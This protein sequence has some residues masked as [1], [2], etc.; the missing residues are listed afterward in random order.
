[1]VTPEIAKS[2]CDLEPEGVEMIEL[3]FWMIRT[4]RLN[5]GFLENHS[6]TMRGIWSPI[7]FRV[8]SASESAGITF[9]RSASY[10]LEELS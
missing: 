6:M 7:L 2:S 3:Q 8:V 1:M 5:V 4:H 10:Y 9:H